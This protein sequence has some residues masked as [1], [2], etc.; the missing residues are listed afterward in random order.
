MISKWE[1]PSTWVRNER[2]KKWMTGAPTYIVP[3][4]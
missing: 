4:H 1:N 3:T 2:E